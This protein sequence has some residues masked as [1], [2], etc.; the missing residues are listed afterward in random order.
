MHCTGVIIAAMALV[1]SASLS[2]QLPPDPVSP[3]G[4]IPPP[5]REWFA[6]LGR[7]GEHGVI[8]G[9]VI[10]AESGAAL[11]RALVTLSAAPRALS[12]F[13]GD[14]GEYELNGLDAGVYVLT[15]SKTGYL[16]GRFGQ[17]QAQTSGTEI[18][19]AAGQT[20]ERVEI[21]LPRAGTIVVRVSDGA[22]RAVTGAQVAVKGR[23]PP[24]PRVVNG[25]RPAFVTPFSN[26]GTNDQGIKR[27]SGLE[28]G[29]YYI[30]AVPPRSP[31]PGSSRTAD[32]TIYYPGVTSVTDAQTVTVGSGQEIHVAFQ[33]EQP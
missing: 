10:A 29:D 33:I 16:T 27:L 28:P 5:T 21:A 3:V 25:P 32:V 26:S 14:E 2:G 19:L 1:G 4:N 8:R 6:A 9:R 11:R 20:L 22:G 7:Q 30:S 23:T 17:T 12:V 24:A 13:T 15:A 31:F 18:R